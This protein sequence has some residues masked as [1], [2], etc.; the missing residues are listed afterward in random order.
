MNAASAKGIALKF[1]RA[2]PETGVAGEVCLPELGVERLALDGVGDFAL[3]NG[4]KGTA[5]I[6]DVTVTFSE[7]C[8]VFVRWKIKD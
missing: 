3:D 1:A 7:K 8:S 5:E 2:T 4:G 6:D